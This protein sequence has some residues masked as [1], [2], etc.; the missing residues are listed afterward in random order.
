MCC[1]G[2]HVTHVFIFIF[3]FFYFSNALLFFSIVQHG[4]PVTHNLT[5]IFKKEGVRVSGKTEDCQRR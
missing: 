1:H 3:I 2:S 5:H 4:D